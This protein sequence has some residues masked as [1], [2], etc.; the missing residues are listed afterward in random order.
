M[1]LQDKNGQN[2]YTEPFQKYKILF[3]EK[4]V[5]NSDMMVHSDMQH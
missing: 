2:I 4:I 3:R 5:I 1:F